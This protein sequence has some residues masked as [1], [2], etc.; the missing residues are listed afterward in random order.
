MNGKAREDQALLITGKAG[1]GKTTLARAVQKLYP[2]GIIV[3]MAMYLKHYAREIGWNGLK[4][5]RGRK[6]LQDFGTVFRDY[7]PYVWVRQ[8]LT[9]W[10]ITYRDYTLFIADDIRYPNEVERIGQFFGI[11]NVTVIRMERHANEL[12]G[13]VAQHA[14]ETEFLQI[15]P[16]FIISNDGGLQELEVEA[17][18]LLSVMGLPI[19][20]GISDDYR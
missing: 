2:G 3:P 1:S 7:D 11:Q 18:K 12:E 5:A 10:V 20:R 16:D 8:S 17:E 6:L 14:S 4:D 19:V 9:E 13:S 15:T